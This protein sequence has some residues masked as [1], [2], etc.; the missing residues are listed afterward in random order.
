M[1][2]NF[3]SPNAEIVL[4]AMDSSSEHVAVDLKVRVCANVPKLRRLIKKIFLPRMLLLLTVVVV[5]AVARD[6]FANSLRLPTD[7]DSETSA[8]SL[9][10][11]ATPRY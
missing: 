3:G 8:D 7:V 11:N 10:G 9:M 4:V 2:R 1:R 6:P 5:V